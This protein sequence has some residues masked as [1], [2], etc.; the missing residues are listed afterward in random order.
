MIEAVERHIP[1]GGRPKG[2][3]YAAW[4]AQAKYDRGVALLRRLRAG[5]APSTQEVVA[6]FG[7]GAR[8]SE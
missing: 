2:N 4:G 5:I 7:K 8:F 3:S 1:E 6:Y